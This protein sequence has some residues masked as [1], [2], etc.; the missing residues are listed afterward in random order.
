MIII[1]NDSF[2]ISQ[3]SNNY[4]ENSIER[5]I[6]DEMNQGFGRYEYDS[7]EELK[8]EIRMRRQIIENAIDLNESEFSFEDFSKSRCNEDFWIRMNIGGFE[9]KE[10]INPSDAINDIF[11]N[12]SRYATECATAVVIIYYKSLVDVFGEEKFNLLFPKIELVGWNIGET[13]LEKAAMPEMVEDII[14]GDRQY[15]YNPDVNPEEEEWQGENVIVMPNYMYYGHG[16]GIKT[17]EE[18]I[19]ELNMN[20]KE[21]ATQSAYLNDTAGRLNFRKLEKASKI[22][23]HIQNQQELQE[24]QSMQEEKE[25]QDNQ[26]ISNRTNIINNTIVWKPFPEP[27]SKR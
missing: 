11:I 16:I 15:F 7:L 17:E 1:R 10:G 6:L 23:L 18:I 5:Q 22:Q 2:D 13:L 24:T 14:L 25:I 21:N 4:P 3:M 26:E 8:F 19:N 12:G 9:L 20:R 27:I